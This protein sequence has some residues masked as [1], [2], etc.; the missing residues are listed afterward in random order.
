[1]YSKRN[2]E[3][4]EEA[5]YRMGHNLCQILVQYGLTSRIDEENKKLNNA[6]TNHPVNKWALELI[7]KFG[8]EENKWLINT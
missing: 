6:N 7:R 4:S 5:V 1:M 3:Q 2:N 8:K